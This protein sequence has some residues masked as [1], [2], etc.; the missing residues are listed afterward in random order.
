MLISGRVPIQ[1]LAF[2]QKFAALV[3]P[4]K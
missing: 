4:C 2:W 1:S 3:C